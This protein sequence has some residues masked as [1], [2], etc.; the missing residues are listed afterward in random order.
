[1]IELGSIDAGVSDA[2]Y[3]AYTK[4]VERLTR[5][6]L[7]DIAAGND[8]IAPK[9]LPPNAASVMSVAQVQEALKAIG[10][11]P[12]AHVDGICGY[13]TQSAIRLFQE[14]VRSVE[15]LPCVP[16]GRFGPQSQAHLQRWLDGRLETVW[17]PVIEA[18]RAAQTG[19]GEYR[20]WLTLLEQVKQQALAHPTRAQQLVNEFR[21]ASDTRK[22]A[23]W[24][25]S[26]AGNIHLVGIRRAEMQGKFDDIFVLLIKGLV[27]KFQGTT[28]PG[29]SENPAGPPF[30]VPGQHDYHFGWHKSSYLALRP[31]S[32]GVLVVRAGADKRL[33]DGD[34]ANGL[35]ANATINIHWGGK[36][37][38]RDVKSW[39][40]GCQTIN[41]TVYLN[42]ANTLVSCAD[43]TAGAPSEASTDPTKTR[44]AYNVLLDLVSALGS[45]LSG[46]K[47]LY[48]LLTD[49][50]LALA[51]DLGAGLAAARAKV[52][53]MPAV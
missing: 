25:F 21:G 22:V 34:L 49:A 16:D 20:D 38:T 8:K 6:P 9:R 48:T 17:S 28:E 41:G 33:D 31:Q 30:L 40:E 23:Q 4:E 5:R 50:D 39:S 7:A 12:G 14:Y 29:A 43:F 47:V 2:T 27:F 44:G 36:G 3:A 51:P 46:G 53:Q 18:W 10:F 26:S 13:R 52:L 1:M 42:A 32:T 45:D 15:R 19:T 11:F 35:E 24:D 37:M